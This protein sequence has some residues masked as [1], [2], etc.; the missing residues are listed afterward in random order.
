MYYL[1]FS[2]VVKK[3]RSLLREVQKL[4]VRTQE[5]GT[6]IEFHFELSEHGV[7]FTILGNLLQKA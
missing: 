5:L 1:S 6:S 7:G 2:L 3:M 4:L